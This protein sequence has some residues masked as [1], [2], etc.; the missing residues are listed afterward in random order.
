LRTLNGNMQRELVTASVARF[1]L[2]IA[3]VPLD[4]CHRGRRTKNEE[5]KT[6]NEETGVSV[7]NNVRPE[8]KSGTNCGTS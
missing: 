4:V 6:K 5:R 3:H 2:P 1:D 7:I 8:E